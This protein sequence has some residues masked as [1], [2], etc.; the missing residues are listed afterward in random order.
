MRSVAGLAPSHLA[1]IAVGTQ[2]TLTS[3]LSQ[4]ERRQ[5]AAKDEDR[6]Q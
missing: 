2:I 3:I 4:W 6:T 5:N 1:G